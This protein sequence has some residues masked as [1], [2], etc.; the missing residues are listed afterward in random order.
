VWVTNKHT[1]TY[2][3]RNNAGGTGERGIKKVSQCV[4]LGNPKTPNP[5]AGESL[6][7]YLFFLRLALRF[8]LKVSTPHTV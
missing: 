8:F 5:P 4:G 7:T 1:K 6:H 3:K 2:L